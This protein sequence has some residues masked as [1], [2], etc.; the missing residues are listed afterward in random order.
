M[1]QATFRFYAE[2]NDFLPTER[3]H[4]EFPHSFLLP[5]SIKDMIKAL[6]V[7]LTEVELIQ[8]DGVPVDF[9][10]LVQD[11]D[12]VS[13][14]PASASLPVTS[15]VQLRS[16]L[17]VFGFVLDTHLGRLATYL[18]M[19]GFDVV[20]QNRCDD[21]E[22]AH[23]SAAEHRVLLSRLVDQIRLRISLY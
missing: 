5:A 22:P 9:S 19:L 4:T 3:R 16:Q 7:P 2:L 21:E 10:Y 12:R 17:Q 18:R 23:I 20:Y 15:V 14:Y 1:R 11:A 8:V 6:G 13:V